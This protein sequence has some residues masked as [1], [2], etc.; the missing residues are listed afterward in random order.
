[1]TRN[2]K[3]LDRKVGE[4]PAVMPVTKRRKTTKRKTVKKVTA[5]PKKIKQHLF[6][7]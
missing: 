1:M 5:A 7:E 6:D 2:K 4:P 3:A